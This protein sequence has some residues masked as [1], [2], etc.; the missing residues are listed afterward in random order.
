VGYQ[1]LPIYHHWWLRAHEGTG[2][3]DRTFDEYY[4]YIPQGNRPRA[5]YQQIA[6]SFLGRE[7][8]SNKAKP[9]WGWHDNRTRKRDAIATGQWALDPAYS[10]SKNLRIPGRFSLDYVYNPYLGIGTPP[11]AMMAVQQPTTVATQTPTSE[12]EATSVPAAPV[13]SVQ[14]SSR[15]L[16][17]RQG[18][19]IDWHIQALTES[20]YQF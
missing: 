17:A 1:L 10:V 13:S 19:V 7:Q 14:P 12:P 4:T 2:R 9:F 15:R 16:P 3:D 8:S 20:G 5:K 18:R 6:G 11:P